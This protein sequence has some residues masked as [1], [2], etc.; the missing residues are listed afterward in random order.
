MPRSSTAAGSPARPGASRAAS[1]CRNAGSAERDA[2][3]DERQAGP[4]TSVGQAGDVIP[5]PS[6]SRISAAAAAGACRP[7]RRA[8][9]RR[10]RGRDRGDRGQRHHRGDGDQRQQ[11]EEHEPPVERLGDDRRERRPEH[12][13]QH[14]RRRQRREHPRPAAAPAGPARSR[15]RRR[16]GSRRHRGPGAPVRGRGS[17]STAPGR[18]RAA[19]SR[20]GRA[21]QD[22][23]VTRLLVDEQPGDRRSR[24]RLPRKKP[25][26]TQPYRARLPAASSAATIGMIVRDGEGL[27][28]DE[29]DRQDEADRQDTVA[30][31]PETG[32]LRHRLGGH[33][34][35][36][37]QLGQ[38]CRQAGTMRPPPARTQMSASRSSGNGGWASGLTAIRT[39]SSGLSSP[40][41]P[42]AGQRAA[43]VA[44]M[45]EDPLAVLAN[46][47]RDRLHRGQ[48]VG[49]AV[50]RVDVEVA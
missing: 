49:C 1:G 40:G 23:R 15:R 47:D 48:A 12:A 3:D 14:P 34:Q 33:G 32:R 31:R 16:P 42:V 35:R 27:G 46:G 39:S 25:E 41:D 19:R 4:R 11:A 36:M 6:V 13:G 30:G 43:A 18:R 5:A 21:R 38:H 28:G 8:R 20:T 44:A 29:R 22:G 7:P 50:A 45:D 17:A 24:R 37:R 2:R 26:K 9:P 10:R